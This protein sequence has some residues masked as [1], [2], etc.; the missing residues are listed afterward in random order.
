MKEE[1]TRPSRPNSKLDKYSGMCASDI[2]YVSPPS[3]LL[4]LSVQGWIHRGTGRMLALF[5]D[6]YWPKNRDASLGDRIY[7]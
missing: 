5:P 7:F 4:F 1:Q 3:L 2:C 6:V